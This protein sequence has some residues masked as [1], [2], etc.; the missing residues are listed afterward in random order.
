M[1]DEEEK[2]FTTI[3]KSLSYFLLFPC[4]TRNIYF[5][6]YNVPLL[7]N[8]TMNETA[9]WK[10]TFWRFLFIFTYTRHRDVYLFGYVNEKLLRIIYSIQPPKFSAYHPQIKTKVFEHKLNSTKHLYISLLVCVYMY[11]PYTRAT[12]PHPIRKY[13]I[14]KMKNL[15]MYSSV[16]VLLNPIFCYSYVELHFTL[17]SCWDKNL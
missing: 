4:Q 12:S 1:K 14:R 9:Y 17:S 6:F 16:C 8:Q 11:M 3:A 15:F 7:F 13:I 5:T 2:L 10:T